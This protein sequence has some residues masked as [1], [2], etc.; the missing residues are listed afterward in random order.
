VLFQKQ[1]AYSFVN[2]TSNPFNKHIYLLRNSLL[3]T[4]SQWNRSQ[5]CKFWVSPALYF[6]FVMQTQNL[7]DGISSPGTAIPYCHIREW[8]TSAVPYSSSDQDWGG[9]EPRQACISSAQQTSS[10]PVFNRDRGSMGA[11]GGMGSGDS[12]GTSFLIYHLFR[13]AEQVEVSQHCHTRS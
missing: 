7:A 13:W 10:D 12:K 1:T 8:I 4:E 6:Y 5:D 9:T 11:K 2:C 3:A